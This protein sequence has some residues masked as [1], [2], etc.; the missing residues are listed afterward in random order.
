MRY[1]IVDGT[2]SIQGK[3]SGLLFVEEELLAE[4]QL[5]A[6]KDGLEQALAKAISFEQ[7]CP[8]MKRAVDLVLECLTRIELAKS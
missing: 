8:T 3:T 5:T 1:V 2:V 6:K 7:C 4:V